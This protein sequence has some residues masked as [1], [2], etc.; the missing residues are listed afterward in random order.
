MIAAAINRGLRVDPLSW[1]QLLAIAQRELGRY[2]QRRVL[3]GAME[4]Y[5]EES[6]TSL[7]AAARIIHEVCRRGSDVVGDKAL[8]L[9]Q[10][11]TGATSDGAEKRLLLILASCAYGMYGNFPS[12]AAVQRSLDLADLQTE[13][14]L[15]AVAISNPRQIPEALRSPRVTPVGRDFLE[16][17]NYFLITG[18]E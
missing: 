5:E 9:H 16:Q 17:L 18:A 4:L 13:G 15:L 10:D 3:D 11:D 8:Q 1:E 6:A 14:Q 7:I 2:Q 12:A